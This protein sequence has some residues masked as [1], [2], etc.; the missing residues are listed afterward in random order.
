MDVRKPVGAEGVSGWTMRE[1]TEQ[2]T[3]PSHCVIK[4]SLRED[5][6][7]E[8]RIPNIISIH[9]TGNKE[10]PLNHRPVFL[11]SEIHK[12]CEKIITKMGEA[13]R[14]QTIIVDKTIVF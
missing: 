8:W 10:H 14:R 3:K 11:T 6:P 1:C 4:S 5:V 13:F 12:M 9:K 2:E 7:Q